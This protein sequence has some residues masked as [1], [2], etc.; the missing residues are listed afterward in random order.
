MMRVLPFIEMQNIKVRADLFKKYQESL[1]GHASLGMFIRDPR[2]LNINVDFRE[3]LR[4]GRYT[5]RICL[6][7]WHQRPPGEHKQSQDQALRHSDVQKWNRRGTS[8]IEYQE[9]G[10]ESRE[11]GNM[12]DTKRVLKGGSN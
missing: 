4:A 12:K 3:E 2:K 5:L 9:L 10:G 6:E 11:C 8:K 1:F 7:P